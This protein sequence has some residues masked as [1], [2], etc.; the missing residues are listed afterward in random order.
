LIGSLRGLIQ[1]KTP[2]WLIL[3][4]GGVGYLVHVPLSTY[5]S[6]PG[7]D[8]EIRLRIYTHVRDDALQ[9]F[10]FLHERE[11]RLF[12]RLID[13]AGIG[14]KLAVTVLSGMEA[15]TLVKAI[16]AEDIARLPTIPGGGKKTAERM[17]LELKD[18]VDELVPDEELGGPRGLRNDVVSALVNLGYRRRDAERAVDKVEDPSEHFEALLKQTLRMLAS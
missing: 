8:E 9:L 13:V 18:K 4:V 16:A 6:L 2:E 11:Q 10:G 7:V 12:E 5:Y 15:Q 17:T 3:D 14:P 1:E